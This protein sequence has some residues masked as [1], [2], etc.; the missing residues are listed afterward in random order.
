MEQE[1]PKRKRTQK[2]LSNIDEHLRKV[3]F[4][5]FKKTHNETK[6]ISELCHVNQFTFNVKSDIFKS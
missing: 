1:N 2:I 5:K 4:P 6:Y 3:G